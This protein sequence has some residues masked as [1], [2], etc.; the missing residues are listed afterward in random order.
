M[1]NGRE[2]GKTLG[3]GWLD[4]I[5]SDVKRTGVS[6]G[7]ARDRCQVDVEDL[8]G[9]PEKLAE[10]AKRKKKILHRVPI[11]QRTSTFI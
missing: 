1:S 7:Y 8:G 3:K 9:P 11:L 5:E 4:V 10:K 2:E 6:V